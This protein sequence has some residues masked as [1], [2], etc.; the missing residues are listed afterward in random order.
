MQICI[1]PLRLIVSATRSYLLFLNLSKESQFEST[2]AL[3]LLTGPVKL[4]Y[5]S[6]FPFY[7]L[8]TITVKWLNW[9]DYLQFKNYIFQIIFL[10]FCFPHDVTHQ[11]AGRGFS[12]QKVFGPSGQVLQVEPDSVGLG[13]RI[14]VDRV[15]PEQ[16]VAGEL[17]ES[18]HFQILEFETFKKIVLFWNVQPQSSK[19]FDDL[20]Q[21][22]QRIERKW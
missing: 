19:L 12:H 11:I 4:W 22:C 8:F 15:E 16:V 7:S 5:T 1:T 21:R 3:V 13:Q 18:R 9:N 17:S 20:S 10:T 6:A 14:E 2:L